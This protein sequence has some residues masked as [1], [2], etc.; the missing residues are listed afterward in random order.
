MVP[1][2][3]NNTTNFDLP[4]PT[5]KISEDK[6][7]RE[8]IIK[9]IVQKLDYQLTRK[10]VRKEHICG[11]CGL[12]TKSLS[13]LKRHI[14]S[15]HEGLRFPCHSCKYRAFYKHDLDNHIKAKHN[16]VAIFKCEN[17][18]YSTHSQINLT[19]HNDFRHEGKTYPC[20]DCSFKAA[21]KSSLKQHTQSI[22][23]NIKYY[24]EDC[25]FS[26]TQ[27]ADITKHKN[28]VH[29][30]IVFECEY[31]NYVG[32]EKIALRRH[33]AS[34]HEIAQR[35]Q[36][37]VCTWKTNIK[38]NLKKHFEAN[39]E[40]KY[41]KH[42]CSLCHQSFSL[43]EYLRRHMKSMHSEKRYKCEICDYKSK[44]KAL[45]K[46]HIEAIH[47]KVIYSCDMC[48]FKS[49][50]QSHLKTHKLN[51]TSQQMNCDKCNYRTNDPNKMEKHKKG[52]HDKILNCEKCTKSYRIPG[53]LIRHI[54]LEHSEVKFGLL[55]KKL[56]IPKEIKNVQCD[57][58]FKMYLGI[59][60]LK[61][62]K[63]KNHQGIVTCDICITAK[64]KSRT[65]MLKHKK[66][67]HDKIRFKCNECKHEATQKGDLKK[68]IAKMHKKQSTVKN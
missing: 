35:F 33:I 11:D 32:K 13:Y 66:S 46:M 45:L 52:R 18:D 41:K 44:R 21:R 2:E 39:H 51:H 62:H 22:H 14:E 7:K 64:F 6:I 43:I 53:N 55:G 29:F 31:C 65:A 19:L 3:I 9:K 23:E 16:R 25:D 34:K 57:I 49:G 37:T 61:V 8:K 67:K 47:D 20:S 40:S 1:I 26:G 10:T 50:W 30:G 58:C 63:R 28:R 36:C 4:L 15:K 59:D 48:D 60:K 17:C 42:I 68:H 5:N 56:K 54:K 12:E 27:K 38:R 24:C